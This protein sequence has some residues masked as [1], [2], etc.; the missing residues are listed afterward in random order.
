MMTIQENVSHT[1][2]YT[3]R[4]RMCVS[5]ELV[6]N[7]ILNHDTV[8]FYGMVFTFFSGESKPA[9]RDYYNQIPFECN[10]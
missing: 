2:A 5:D 6:T 1:P 8:R 4:V 10:A 7:T 9:W 3:K